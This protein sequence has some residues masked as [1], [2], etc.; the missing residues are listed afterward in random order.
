MQHSGELQYTN[1]LYGVSLNFRFICGKNNYFTEMVGNHLAET[2]RFRQTRLLAAW[3][4]SKKWKYLAG[5]DTNTSLQDEDAHDNEA[6]SKKQQHDKQEN[7]EGLEEATKNGTAATPIERNAR[8][9]LPA[10]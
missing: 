7:D 9:S 3:V 10:C 8:P 6:H 2:G 1:A 5:I 4:R